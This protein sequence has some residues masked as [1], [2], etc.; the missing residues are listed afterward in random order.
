MPW[1]ILGWMP[2]LV[3]LAGWA[4]DNLLSNSNRKPVFLLVS[5][6]LFLGFLHAVWQC[7][8]LNYRYECDQANPYVYAHT[9]KDIGLVQKTMTEL[10][11]LPGD[12][13]LRIDV[14]FSGHD[15][16]PLPWYL[17]TFKYVGWW[18]NLD[19]EN[20][21]AP[22]ILLSTDQEE[23]LLKLIYEVTPL[24]RRQ[25]YMDLFGRDIELRPGLAM[26]GYISYDLWQKLKPPR[27][28][29]ETHP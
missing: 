17:R 7:W 25:L 28:T 24:E 20:P 11:A 22:V 19:L 15:Y 5:L 16:W 12:A 27:Q 8:Q 23:N 2:S 10:A 26:R 9:G 6:I 1:N 29:I 14:I 4:I 13:V 3:I 21:P 18:N